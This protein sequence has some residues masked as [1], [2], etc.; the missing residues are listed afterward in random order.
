MVILGTRMYVYSA[1]GGIVGVSAEPE[2]VG[3]LLWI[4]SDFGAQVIAPSPIPVADN[5]VFSCAGYGAGSI[6]LEL[7]SDDDTFSVTTVFRKN[8]REG[9]TLEQQS[10]LVYQNLIIGIMPKDAGTLRDQF[11]AYDSRGEFVWSSGE[12]LRYGLGPFVI[13][14]GIA[15]ILDDTGDLTLAEVSESGMTVLDETRILPGVDSWAPLAITGGVLLAR[16]STTMVC[17]DLRQDGWV[18]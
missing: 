11:V 7:S 12:T 6:M 5:R 10:P 2:N 9:L 4:S 8:P 16:D 3:E 13:A 15:I 17:V 1:I 14:D 18:E